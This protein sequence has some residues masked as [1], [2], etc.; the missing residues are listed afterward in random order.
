MN[1]V[2]IRKKQTY[3]KLREAMLWNEFFASSF[4]LIF[5]WN[6]F[7]IFHFNKVCIVH[8]ALSASHLAKVHKQLHSSN[9]FAVDSLNDGSWKETKTTTQLGA[10]RNHDISHWCDDWRCIGMSW[11]VSNLTMCTH[12][13]N[14]ID[15]SECN[16]KRSATSPCG[17]QPQSADT[18]MHLSN[19]MRK[20]RWTRD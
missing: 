5:M 20:S 19:Q 14:D 11:T 10:V 12:I 16:S 13:G 15:N 17:I 2:Q 9:I 7:I 8:Y 6:R 1:G 4:V 3:Y 18:V